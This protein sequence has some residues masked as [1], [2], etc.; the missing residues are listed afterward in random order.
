MKISKSKVYKFLLRC[1]IEKGGYTGNDIKKLA[2]ILKVSTRILRKWINLWRDNDPDFTKIQYKGKQ[3]ISLS[4]NELMLIDQW[5]IE[6]LLGNVSDLHRELN[7]NRKIE[8]K[9]EIPST[10]FYNFIANRKKAIIGDIPRTLEWLSISGIKVP[11]TYDLVNARASLAE[12]FSYSNLKFFNGIDIDAIAQRL[13]GAQEWFKQYYPNVNPYEWHPQIRPRAKVIRNQLSRIKANKSLA[14]QARLVFEAQVDFIVRLK[15]IYIDELI[16]KHGWLQRSMSGKRPAMENIMLNEW[17]ETCCE[18]GDAAATDSPNDENIAQL[19]EF[20]NAGKPEREQAVLELISNYQHDFKSL[21]E[22]FQ[23]LTDNFCSEKIVYHHDTARVLLDLCAGRRKWDE[24]DEQDRKKLTKIRR[25]WGDNE[26]DEYLEA[27]LT[28]KLITYI[29]EG[30]I[31][32]RDSFKYQDL[33]AII[34]QVEL[35]ED[36][37]LVTYNDLDQLIKGTYPLGIT[38]ELFD[39]PKNPAVKPTNDDDEASQSVKIPFQAV[40]DRVENIVANHNPTWFQDHQA[41]FEKMTDG[42]FQMEYDEETFRHHLYDAIGFLGR[43]L[44]YS[45][46]PGFYGLQYFNQRFLSDAT[47]DLEFRHLWKVFEDLTGQKI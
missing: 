47:L 6:K 41:V 26:P 12:I 15:D 39:F 22:H 17:I 34:E 35:S 43:N 27:I 32:L 5:L 25:V 19:M 33:G 29:H 24:I 3:S 36:D 37:W 11:E 40:R 4:F 14:I 30:K 45:D 2:K 1:Q 16:H 8:G 42:V 31:T 13:N 10:T 28:K 46:P 18:I 44:R 38:P 9:Q 21:F 23:T 20:I 7:S